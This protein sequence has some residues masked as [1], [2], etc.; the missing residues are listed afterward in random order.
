MSIDRKRVDA[1]KLLEDMGYVYKDGR[2]QHAVASGNYTPVLDAQWITVSGGI[3][4]QVVI[5]AQP[6]R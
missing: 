6:Q 1:V 2:W 5:N 4:S 3:S